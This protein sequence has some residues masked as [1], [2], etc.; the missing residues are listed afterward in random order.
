[1]NSVR[2][3]LLARNR[4]RLHVSLHW[5]PHVP[6][7]NP[8]CPDGST[9]PPL[10]TNGGLFGVVSLF[11]GRHGSVT[12][13]LWFHPPWAN[14]LRLPDLLPRTFDCSHQHNSLLCRYGRYDPNKLSGVCLAL[15]LFLT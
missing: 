15:C 13:F 3:E 14:L 12:R 11:G 2:C 9:S 5:L 1:M 8:L 7:L 4:W 10:I 6:Q